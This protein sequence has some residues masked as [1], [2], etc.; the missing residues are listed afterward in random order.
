[1]KWDDAC[2]CACEQGCD[3]CDK[4]TAE[5]DDTNEKDDIIEM[6]DE[7]DSDSD[8]S[9]DNPTKPIFSSTPVKHQNQVLKCEDCL[10]LSQ[11]KACRIIQQIEDKYDGRQDMK[12]DMRV[13][14]I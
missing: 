8:L 5:K 12:T 14:W 3:D 13:S 2:P 9:K 6:L 4:D 10:N 7:M 1:M 11:C